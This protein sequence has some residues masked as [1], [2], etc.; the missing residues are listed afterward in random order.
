[1]ASKIEV[2]FSSVTLDDGIRTISP[3]ISL[4][5]PEDDIAAQK[6][7]NE[8]VIPLGTIRIRY[9][10]PLEN[11][12][13]HEYLA[14]RDEGFTRAYLARIIS[15]EYKKIYQEEEAAVGDP[16]HVPGMLNRAPSQGPYGIWGHDLGDLLLRT[17]EQSDEEKDLFELGF[18]L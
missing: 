12:V 3:Y 1:M 5:D 4:A 9:D 15:D 2:R 8:L 11:E 7:P 13:I 18:K 6:A 10:Y 17:V 14:D 16:G